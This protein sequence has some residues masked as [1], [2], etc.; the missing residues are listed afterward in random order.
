MHSQHNTKLIHLS[1]KQ[2][3]KKK[4]QRQNMNNVPILYSLRNPIQMGNKYINEKFMSNVE[5]INHLKI[6]MCTHKFMYVSISILLI[7]ISS[8]ILKVF[9]EKSL[10]AAKTHF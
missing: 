2:V 4:N 3:I 7:F 8:S 9:H 10:N 6:H 1:N 5:K